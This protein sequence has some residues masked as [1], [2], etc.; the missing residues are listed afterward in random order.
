MKRNDTSFHEIRLGN[1]IYKSFLCKN[2][3]KQMQNEHI[4]AV[5]LCVTMYEDENELSCRKT[6]S[7]LFKMRAIGSASK[8]V[9]TIDA[10]V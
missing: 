6:I 10:P 1:V 2:E 8:V 3:T 4:F 5:L 9:R 7:F